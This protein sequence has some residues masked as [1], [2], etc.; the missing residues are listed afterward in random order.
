MALRLLVDDVD[1]KDLVELLRFSHRADAVH[2]LLLVIPRR[3]RRFGVHVNDAEQASHGL[4]SDPLVAV[5]ILPKVL[6]LVADRGILA[7]GVVVKANRALRRVKVVPNRVSTNTDAHLFTLKDHRL[8]LIVW[9]VDHE[10]ASREGVSGSPPR[11][12]LRGSADAWE[13]LWLT[14][15]SQ[16]HALDTALVVRVA[17]DGS[18]FPQRSSLR[19]D[20]SLNVREVGR[21]DGH[22]IVTLLHLI[23]D[24][25]VPVLGVGDVR[26][27]LRRIVLSAVHAVSDVPGEDRTDGELGLHLEDVDLILVLAQGL[28]RCLFARSHRFVAHG[29]FSSHNLVDNA[30]SLNGLKGW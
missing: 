5:S 7:N 15:M 22:L 1:S 17:H 14:S 26:I 13:T 10:M 18:C 16:V 23:D 6:D 25:L 30:C 19:R 11:C 24:I 29:V 12:Q 9:N 27:R 3:S 28:L 8:V 2:I 4:L 21:E 20:G